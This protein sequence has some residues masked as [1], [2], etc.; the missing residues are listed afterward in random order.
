[1]ITGRKAFEAKSQA[2][3]ISAILRDDPPPVDTLV[4]EVPIAIAR[5]I[6]RCLVKDPEDRWQ[7]ASDL[8][9]Q[10]RFSNASSG[11]RIPAIRLG[12]SSRWLERAAWT[13]ALV[14]L[15]VVLWSQ[16]TETREQ[17][18]RAGDVPVRFSLFPAPGVFL[19]G[20]DVPLAVSPDGRK[21]AYVGT[22]ANGVQQL[23]LRSLDSEEQRA[24]AG[25]EG[26]STP[27][28]SPDSQWIG[29]F[30]ENAL[31]K[32]RISSGLTQVVAAGVS[33]FGGAT[34]NRDDVILFPA[35]RGALA[36]VS[37][38]GGP[39]SRLA[40]DE[41]VQFSP[42]F[43]GDQK[44]FIY[45]ES[46]AGTLR[47]GSVDDEPSRTLMTF[48]VRPSTLGYA[49]G[50]VFFVQDST[51]FARPLDARRLEFSGDP[52]R[53][54][55]G[56]PVTNP[57]RAPFSVSEA[58]VLAFWPSTLGTPSVLRWFDRDGRATPALS[59]PAQ[60][61]G[62][63][64]SSDGRRLIFSRIGKSGTDLWLRDVDG[65]GEIQ[66]TFEGGAV[67]PQWSPDAVRIAYTGY[68][69]GPPPKLYV[70]NVKGS[71]AASLVVESRLPNFASSWS[72]DGR[73]IVSVRSTDPAKRHDLW[74]QRLP[75]GAA[76]PLAFNTSSNEFHGKVSPD[77]R[78]IA[79]TTDQSGKDEVWVA[80]FPDGGIPIQVSS[81][82]G[83]FPQW[84]AVD[85][86]VYVSKDKKL[87]TARVDASND[88]IVPALP[89]ALFEVAKVIDVD[90]FLW[91]S[92]Y[93]YDVTPDG[94][95]F[96]I[97][98]SEPDPQ[99]PPV[100]VIVNWPALLEP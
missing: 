5:T 75:D 65:G 70:R 85:E 81:G 89:K 62:F 6:E 52:I 49:R 53:I 18:P 99:T 33:T 7:S 60:Y 58:G 71:E 37:A 51:L 8:L 30:A 35:F 50:H 17:P 56:I 57:S 38:K 40:V 25:T 24:L 77:G 29:F 13:A 59:T 98:V 91:P 55:D 54:V 79:Y 73:S 23:W 39:V 68:G 96:L 16:R 2:E 34:W 66:F 14:V 80:S 22:S 20:T 93:P 42:H 32:V 10:L 86:I 26:A 45:A 28:W 31:K 1:M 88:R 27:F 12:R 76:V 61:R 36:R 9:F 63:S 95:R 92:A 21:L 72:P 74:I 47:V 84:G 100:Q 87:M 90:T 67:T 97:A 4:P 41:G 83:S 64:L 82:G 43:L 11:S 44:H 15:G 3:L 19:S 48:P 78:W 46:P 94:R 69:Q